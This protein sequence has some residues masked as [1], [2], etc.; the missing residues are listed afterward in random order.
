MIRIIR[1]VEPDEIYHLAAQSHVKISF[2]VPE[3]TAESDGI[4]TLRL[5]EAVRFLGLG[6]STKIYNAATSELYGNIPI[7]PQ[8]EE[9][10]FFPQSPYACAKVFS[11]HITKVY[12]EAYNM[13]ASNGILFNH[14]SPLRG[15]EFVTR[16]V[17][18]GI[19]HIKKGWQDKIVLGNLD[20]KRDWGYAPEYVEAMWLMLQQKKPEDYVIASGETYS[21]RDFV[22]LAFKTAGFDIVW[23]GEGITEKGIDEETGEILIE[24]S[25]KF[26][27]PAE[28]DSLSGDYSKA[29]EK[30]GWQP[31]KNFEELVRIMVD[32]DMQR[33]G[34]LRK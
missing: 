26:F 13:F 11:F 24:V 32:A 28:V 30:L 25:S 10:P 22:E 34:E 21:V 2:E 19:A 8:N 27:R 9:T 7:A 33:V 17:T 5:L 14:E 18:Y 23:E 15:F 31:K 29:K 12:R 20:S 3:Y 6:D 16:K 4:G 1:E